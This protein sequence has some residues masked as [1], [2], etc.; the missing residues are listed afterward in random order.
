MAQALR[1]RNME[2]QNST[3]KRH[4]RQIGDLIKSPAL[5]PCTLAQ[6]LSVDTALSIQSHPDK[7]LAARLHAERPEVRAVQQSL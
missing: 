7:E 6:V 2:L 4:R 5:K 3:M 1:D